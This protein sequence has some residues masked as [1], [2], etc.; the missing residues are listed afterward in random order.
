MYDLPMEE[1]A[2]R[3]LSGETLETIAKDY[4]HVIKGANPIVRLSKRLIK[5]GVRL[6]SHNYARGSKNNF[7]KDGEKRTAMHYYRR[8]SYEV[9]AICIGRP[10][11]PGAVIHH[12]DENHCNNNPENLAVFPSQSNHARYHR[13]LLVILR[14]GHEVDTIQLALKN[15]GR[16]L[17][18]CASLIGLELHTDPLALSEKDL[19]GGRGRKE[20]R[21]LG[22]PS[23]QSGL[24]QF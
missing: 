7:W 20:W 4:A 12:F 21:V 14:K 10:L 24:L 6:G 9:A 3:A 2:K 23:R 17:Q 11:E 22:Q 5:I 8:Q 1:I 19:R 15:G 16:L 13:Q 18:R